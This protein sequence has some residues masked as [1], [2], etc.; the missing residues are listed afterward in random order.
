M[1][2]K[3]SEGRGVADVVAKLRTQNRILKAF[4]A[5]ALALPFIFMMMGARSPVRRQVF[6]EIDVNRINIVND[7]GSRSMVLAARG[8]LPDIVLDGKIEKSD[9]GKKMPGMLFYNGVG[10][11]VGGLI[12]DGYIDKDGKPNGGVH[13]SMDRY[14]GDQQLALHHYENGGSMETGLS[15]FDRGLSRQYKGLYEKY[16]AAPKGVEKDALLKQWK[17]AGGQQTQRLFVGRTYG[18][19]SAVILADDAGKPRII[20]SVEP[21][22]KASL[23]FINDKGDVIQSLPGN[24]AAS[25]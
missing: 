10:D 4:L 14:G 25:R 24:S 3:K 6:S 2:D 12:Y 17:E 1:V 5:L 22:G 15:I 18:K 7:D 21:N 8:F 13:F 16:L 9:R 23:D 11:E 19:S 20:M